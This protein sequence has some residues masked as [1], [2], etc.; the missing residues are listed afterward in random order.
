MRSSMNKIAR[1]LGVTCSADIGLVSI[2]YTCLEGGESYSQV[3]TL[4]GTGVN[5][6]NLQESNSLFWIFQKNTVTY[7]L[8]SFIRSWMNRRR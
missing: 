5:T 3:L 8:K 1:E 4:T 7:L 2:E 6:E